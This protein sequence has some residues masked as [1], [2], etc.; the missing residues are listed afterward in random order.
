VRVE[1]L[2]RERVMARRGSDGGAP[3][4]WAPVDEP[5]QADLTFAN[6]MERVGQLGIS[7]FEGSRPEEAL[8]MVLRLEYT[9]V[10][11]EPLGFLELYRG[12]GDGAYSLRTERTRITAAAITLLAERVQEGLAD[13]F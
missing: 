3:A 9:G 11:G 2:G 13:L 12:P 10:G 6:F 5:A 8:E 4:V 7:G 1:T